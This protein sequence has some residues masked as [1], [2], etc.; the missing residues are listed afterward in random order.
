MLKYS[1]KIST[2]FLRTYV[3]L[4]IQKILV[5]VWDRKQENYM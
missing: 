4:N 2:I 1:E 3:C 5:T